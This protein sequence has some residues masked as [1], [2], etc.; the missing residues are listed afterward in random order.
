MSTGKRVIKYLS[1]C[2]ALFLVFCIF[3]CIINGIYKLYYVI[4]PKNDVSSSTL[5]RV[6]EGNYVQN[7]DIDLLYSDLVIK[8][9]DKLYIESN[10]SNVSYKVDNDSLIIKEKKNKWYK[11]SDYEVVIY[12]PSG[13]R[14]NSIDIDN[15]AGNLNINGIN[16]LVFDLDLGAGKSSILDISA[17]TADIDNG[18]GSFSIN[19]GNIHDLDLD[20]GIGDVKISSSITGKASIDTGVGNLVLDLLGNRDSY[21]FDVSKGIGK[22]RIGEDIINKDSVVGDGNTSIEISGG[23]SNVYVNFTGDTQ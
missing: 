16:T 20:I 11:N 21:K 5:N 9:G 23:I 7:I 10:N 3:S 14:F 17:Y 2:L 22:I 8:E 6:W 4:Y 18:A 19:R 1:I 12:I 15:G 13:M